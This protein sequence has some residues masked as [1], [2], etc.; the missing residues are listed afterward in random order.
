WVEMDRPCFGFL[1]YINQWDSDDVEDHSDDY[2]NCYQE[3]GLDGFEAEKL[4]AVG[5]IEEVEAGFLSDIQKAMAGLPQYYGGVEVKAEP[6]RYGQHR[7]TFM[8]PLENQPMQ[9]ATI[10]GM[11]LRNV[12]CYSSQK[13]SF[14]RLIKD[15][16]DHSLAF[17]IAQIYPYRVN[18]LDKSK[19]GFYRNF[20]GDETI[21]PG[22][23]RVCDLVAA[24]KGKLGDCWQGVFGD[25]ENGY[26]RYGDYD[27]HLAPLCPRTGYKKEL[28][29]VTL[30]TEG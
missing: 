29:N 30:L 26:G 12:I 24:V 1:S 11:M 10:A 20:G 25:T 5:Y 8:I 6:E 9:V 21:F 3:D 2:D 23:A 27:G 18:G 22:A 7:V 15:G 19:E 16:V 4:K 28:A 14:T 13:N 17:L